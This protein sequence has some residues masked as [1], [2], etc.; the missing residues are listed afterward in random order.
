LKDDD[1][2]NVADDDDVNVLLPV[3][4]FDKNCDS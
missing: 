1:D 4:F 3:S 2:D